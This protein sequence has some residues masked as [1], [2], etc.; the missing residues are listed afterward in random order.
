[1]EPK[2]DQ[3]GHRSKE[4]KKYSFV[5]YVHLEIAEIRVSAVNVLSL[6]TPRFSRVSLLGAIFISAEIMS[7]FF[8]LS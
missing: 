4:K 7:F 8:S 2:G 6:N 3:I 5:D 1:M